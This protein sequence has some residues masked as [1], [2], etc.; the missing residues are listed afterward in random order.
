MT[1]INVS[2]LTMRL[3][4]SFSIFATLYA[5]F[6]ITPPTGIIRPDKI[7]CNIWR[8][9][10]ILSCERISK[11]YHS[12]VIKMRQFMPLPI[13]EETTILLNHSYLFFVNQ[14]L[15]GYL[16]IY[17]YLPYHLWGLEEQ[18]VILRR[19]SYHHL[20]CIVLNKPLNI[21]L[22]LRKFYAVY[23]MESFIFPLVLTGKPNK[24]GEAFDSRLGFT[25]SPY[26]YIWSKICPTRNQLPFIR[27]E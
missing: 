9:D 12:D 3:F 17:P 15:Q 20:S 23:D 6:T 18:P 27:R 21:A 13:P 2:S 25:P 24:E 16:T 11:R 4:N 22:L 8:D 1:S 26:P 7:K 19:S 10:M 5:T 14:I